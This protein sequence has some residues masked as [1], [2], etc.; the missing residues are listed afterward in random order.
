MHQKE[1]NTMHTT[2]TR[3]MRIFLIGLCFHSHVWMDANCKKK[4]IRVSFEMTM[5]EGEK[6]E[7]IRIIFKSWKVRRIERHGEEVQKHE[8]DTTTRKNEEAEFYL[9]KS[10]EEEKFSTSLVLTFLFKFLNFFGGHDKCQFNRR[11]L[12]SLSEKW[13]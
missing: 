7:E 9:Q 4:V 8:R 10:F 11:F 1:V 6:I 13:R 3:Q 5:R 12:I 2:T